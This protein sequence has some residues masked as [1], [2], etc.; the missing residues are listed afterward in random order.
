MGVLETMKENG[1]AWNPTMV[2]YESNR[3][4]SRARTIPWRETL[5]LPSA[6][7]GQGPDSTRHG[8]YKTEWKTSDEVMWKNN[9]AIWMKYVLAFHEMGGL[10]T[11]GSDTNR[12][13][14][15]I[16]ELE[17]LQEA[18]LHPIDVIRVAT[19][20]A[21]RALGMED[22]CGVRVGCAADL[23]VV[24]G[25]PI[26][27]LKVLYGLGYGF[28]GIAPA[29]EQWKW[30]GVRWTIKD[31]VVYDAPALL[32]EVLWYVDQQRGSP[33]PVTDVN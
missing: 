31:G 25:N 19:T 2:V 30:G 26:D 24:N 16:R 9:Y 18:G 4:L 14:S 10:L 33:V 7:Q 23:V 1:T 28:F 5:Y 6:T 15:L 20:N 3:D 11:A 21:Y 27:N 29:S 8:G 13:M 12:G 17:L 32:R 22:H